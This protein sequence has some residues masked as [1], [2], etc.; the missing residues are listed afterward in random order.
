MNGTVFSIEEFSVYDGPGIRTSVF[1]KGC[2]LRCSWCHNPEGQEKES[3]ILRS[4]NGCIECG[5]C[6][7]YADDQGYTVASMEHCPRQLLRVCGQ[8]WSGEEL[9]S[10]ILK[11]RRL[12][13]GV[14]FS[15]GEPLYQGDFLVDCLKLLD[16][17][18]H[19][20]VQTSGYAG[21][22]IFQEMLKNTDYVL[23]DLKVMDEQMHIAHTGVSNKPIL[24][25]FRRLVESG[26]DFV[27]R[28]PLIPGVTDTVENITAIARLLQENGIDYAEILPYNKMAGAKY[29]LAG[30]VFAPTFDPSVECSTRENL[31]LNYGI[32]VKVY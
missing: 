30:K 1:L 15:G 18:L 32:K 20:A 19:R 17:Q 26:K 31:F 21:G 22:A 12:L 3:K 9:V 28:V 5:A 8:V 2:P 29:K 24:K 7:R 14:T 4:P 6:Q 10:Q 11:N 25:N 23:F 13:D 27:I 16:G